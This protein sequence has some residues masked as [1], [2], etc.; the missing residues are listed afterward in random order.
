MSNSIKTKIVRIGNSQG[1]R[2]PKVF[3]DQVNFGKDVE[4]ELQENRIVIKSAQAP[5]QGWEEQFKKMAKHGDDQFTD[6]EVQLSSWDD[7]EWEW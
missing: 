2:I 1:V 6:L 4:L 7:I 5:R 3:L